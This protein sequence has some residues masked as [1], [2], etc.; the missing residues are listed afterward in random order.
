[1]GFFLP[2]FKGKRMYYKIVY[3]MDNINRDIKLEELLEEVNQHLLKKYALANALKRLKDGV[4][5][6]RIDNCTEP[7]L[8]LY[9][10]F[11]SEIELQ[12]K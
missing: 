5:F 7:K 1:V 11:Y 4:Y 6:A 8:V 3:E 10:R 9:N 2:K 12:Q